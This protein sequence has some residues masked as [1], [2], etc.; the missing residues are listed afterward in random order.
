MIAVFLTLVLSAGPEIWYGC[1]VR[2]HDVWSVAGV[3][4]ASTVAPASPIVAWPEVVAVQPKCE[5]GLCG[6]SAAKAKPVQRSVRRGI[7]GRTRR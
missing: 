1:E 3:S 7:F 5:N 6:V 2:Q 4:V